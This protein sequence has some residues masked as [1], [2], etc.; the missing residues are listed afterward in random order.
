ME[1]DD[2]MITY[3][4]N[5][6]VISQILH[7]MKGCA[8]GPAREDILRMY[9]SLPNL[10]KNKSLQEVTNDAEPNLSKKPKLEVSSR[11][12]CWLDQFGGI[13]IV[14]HFI[15]VGII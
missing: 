4:T 1:Y 6:R 10:S 11:A 13:W 8:S 15:S 7:Y 14:D 12:K 2:H 3:L 9:N 5:E